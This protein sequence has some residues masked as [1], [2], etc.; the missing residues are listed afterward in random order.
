MSGGALVL[1]AGYSRR[2][3]SDKRRFAVDGEPLLARTVAIAQ[4]AGLDCRLC[5]KPEEAGLPDQ[6]GID[7]A[8]VIPCPDAALGM[9]STLAQGVA[10]CTDWEKLLVVLG[11]MAWVQAATLRAVFAS[12][13][14]TTMVQPFFAGRPGQPVGFGERFF[15]ELEALSGEHG[16][17]DILG[18]HTDA[19]IRLEVAD[20]GIHRDLDEPP[21]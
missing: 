13:T 3:G 18:R 5:L 8:T 4:A 16:G 1:A 7:G 19:L 2:F 11:D 10:A 6:L 9:G 17:R 21:V 12:L 20:P 15:P 14:P